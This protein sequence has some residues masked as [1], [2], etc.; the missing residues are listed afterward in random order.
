MTQDEVDAEIILL[1]GLDPF[2]VFRGKYEL[3]FLYKLLS[4][5]ITDAN[6]NHHSRII[7]KK[8]SMS[9]NGKTFMADLSQWADIPESLRA[10][11]NNLPKMAA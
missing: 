8:V 3:N 2:V 7:Q 4:F 5:L 11:L 6:A 1:K 9:L 10:Y